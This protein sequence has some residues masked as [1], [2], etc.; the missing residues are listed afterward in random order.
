MSIVLVVRR[1]YNVAK[2]ALVRRQ[3]IRLLHP[4]GPIPRAGLVATAKVH[5]SVCK[6]ACFGA[7]V[8]ESCCCSSAHFQTLPLC[9]PIWGF[10]RLAHR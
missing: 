4:S 10:D 5:R 7:A 3:P 6:E 8:V 2:S 9:R 1:C